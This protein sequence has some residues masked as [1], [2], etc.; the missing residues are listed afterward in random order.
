MSETGRRMN[1]LLISSDQHRGD[2]YGFEGRRVRT[3]HLDAMASRG[4]RF[5]ACI[6]PNLVCQPACCP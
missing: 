6:T 3:P 4:T 2:S 5:S 1:I